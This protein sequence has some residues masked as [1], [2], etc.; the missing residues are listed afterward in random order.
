MKINR[1][2]SFS[3]IFHVFLM[4]FFWLSLYM[5]KVMMV[6]DKEVSFIGVEN[7]VT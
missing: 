7:V 4:D 5:F 6:L 1:K 3:R 2:F